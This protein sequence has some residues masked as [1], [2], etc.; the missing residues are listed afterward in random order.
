MATDGTDNP[1]P[2]HHASPTGVPK[3]TVLYVWGIG[4]ETLPLGRAPL[5]GTHYFIG[6]TN[7]RDTLSLQL[8]CKPALQQSFVCTLWLVLLNALYVFFFLVWFRF[9]SQFLPNLEIP[10]GASLDFFSDDAFSFSRKSVN[11]RPPSSLTV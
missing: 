11:I 5:L 8:P 2:M 4:K 3:M 10:E 7:L 1:F 6:S 9:S